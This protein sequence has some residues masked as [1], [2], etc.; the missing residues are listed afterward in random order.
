MNTPLKRVIDEHPELFDDNEVDDMSLIL[1]FL[2][3]KMKGE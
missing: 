1:F 2:Y 3:E